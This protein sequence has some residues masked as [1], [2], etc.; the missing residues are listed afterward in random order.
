[1]TDA[2]IAHAPE[3]VVLIDLSSIAYP[4]WHTSASNPDP[5]H[6][7]TQ[8]VARVRQLTIGHP[9]AALCCDGGGPSFRKEIAPSYKANRPERDESLQHQIALAKEQLE[10]DGFPA[11]TVRGMEADDVIASAAHALRALEQP[12]DVLIVSA[13]K[14]LLQLV[15]PGVK[16]K[17]P[18]TGVVFDGDG[19]AQKFGVRPEQMRDFLTLVGDTADNVK[20]ANGVGPKTA[21]ELLAKFRTL[22]ALFEQMDEVGAAACGIKPS[23][24]QSLRVFKAEALSQTRHLITLKM[25]VPLPLAQVLQ[26]RA[27]RALDEPMV[28]A[29][30]EPSDEQA[31]PVT[32]P[33][34][35][36]P[37]LAM[38]PA[39]PAAD[40]AASVPV[41]VGAVEWERALD[42]R[43]LRDAQALAQN[44]HTSR[45]FSAYGS[46]Q[47]VLSTIMVGREL[48]LPAM[49]SLRGIHNIE[50]KHSLSAGLMVAIVLKSGMAEYFEPALDSDGSLL[51]SDVSAT[52]VTKRKGARHEMRLTHTFEM[53]RQAW[54]KTKPDWEKA[55]LA[56]G[57][58]R[59]PADMLVARVSARLARLIYGDL[60]AGLYTPEELQE[61]REGNAA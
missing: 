11:W 28:L 51:I 40:E 54:P 59:N 26:P 32:E 13:D 4:I 17:S 57:W 58:G 9:H 49:S 44:M 39:K 33:T 24:A 18:L 37:H 56:S 35:A 23:N 53:A 6:A 12:R 22:D 21:A 3:A 30:D 1:M 61:V 50:G 45:M 16:V 52:Y 19:V 31:A 36:A 27:A 29:D 15:Q 60:I 25:D 41:L 5:N 8:I 43:S 38:V 46:P 7:S 34:P 20:G 14:D 2:T 47:A 48:G 42:P 55:F 10:A